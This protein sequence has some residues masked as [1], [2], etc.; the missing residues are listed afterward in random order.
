MSEGR[1]PGDG[2]AYSTCASVADLAQGLPTVS[3]SVS[4][5]CRRRVRTATCCC[6][7][8]TLSGF[9]F[10]RPSSAERCWIWAFAAST[11]APWR[12]SLPAAAT[13]CRV[14]GCAGE[15]DE[16]REPKD[17][18]IGSREVEEED[19]RPMCCAMSMRASSEC[20]LGS[21]PCL[22]LLLSW[23]GDM[24]WRFASD[25]P[26]LSTFSLP[27]SLL[28]LCINAFIVGGGPSC[29]A[30]S[31]CPG[32]S[33]GTRPGRASRAR[34]AMHAFLNLACVACRLVAE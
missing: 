13:F 32:S 3:N 12:M 21:I 26:R 14:L 29:S 20:D 27:F 16:D 17:A 33:Q 34:R 11:S 22:K 24:D 31:A 1:A 18:R 6:R 8:C 5:C 30:S 4:L 19:D 23:L 25:T 9:C 10:R 7:F 2:L 28:L 15:E